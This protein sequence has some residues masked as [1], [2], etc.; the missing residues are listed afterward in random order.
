MLQQLKWE[1]IKAPAN[2]ENFLALFENQ[3]AYIEIDNFLTPAECENIVQQL[4]LLGLHQY[5]YNFATHEAPPAA[6]LFATHYLYEGKSLEEYLTDA[7]KSYKIY[8]NLIKQTGCDPVKKM[9]TRL[10]EIMK[11]PVEVAQEKNQSYFHCIARELNHSV[12]L[13][14]DFAP[15][16]APDRIISQISSQFAWN[17]YL[18]DPKEGGVTTVYN[19]PWLG[20]ADDKLYMT[21]T[22]GYAKEAVAGAEFAQFTVSPG[23]LV[24]FN[25]RNYHEVTATK[26]PRVSIGG[27]LGLT[28]DGRVIAWS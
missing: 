22:Y 18:T 24:F 6:H 2:E 11:R 5:D 14:P 13:H 8:N 15:Y 19:R 26:E 7:E 23:K 4:R 10:S 28:F 20:P 3:C 16:Q 12:L 1:K 17:I 9:L 21:N 25:S 27:H